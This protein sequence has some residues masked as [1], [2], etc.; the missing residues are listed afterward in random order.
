MLAKFLIVY[1]YGVFIL[2]VVSVFYMDRAN[3]DLD[4]RMEFLATLVLPIVF[5][6][7]SVV[8]NSNISVKQAIWACATLIVFVPIVFFTHVALSL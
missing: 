1:L 7:I 4:S 8:I 6:C 2:N 5:G 3:N